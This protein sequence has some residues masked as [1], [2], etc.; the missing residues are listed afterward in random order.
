MVFNTNSQ[1]KETAPLP[2]F[3]DIEVLYPSGERI[4]YRMY[5]EMYERTMEVFL[6][7]VQTQS[8]KYKFVVAYLLNWSDDNQR[9]WPESGKSYINLDQ[10][11]SID[12]IGVDSDRTQ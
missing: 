4:C 9:C 11:C 10:I 5:S 1:K 7:M 6:G 2:R 3:R 12:V 8:N